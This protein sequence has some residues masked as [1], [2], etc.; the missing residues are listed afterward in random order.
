MNISLINN[1]LIFVE[2]F[3]NFNFRN[4]FGDTGSY[5]LHIIELF[6][7]V[8]IHIKFGEERKK[9]EVLHQEREKR[10]I[11]FQKQQELILSELL[12]KN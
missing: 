10:D 9:N 7:L 3:E 4:F 5:F 11:I 2:I 8:K 6:F 12:K 1:L